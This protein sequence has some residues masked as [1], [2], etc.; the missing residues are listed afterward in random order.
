[1]LSVLVV[2]GAR[3]GAVVEALPSNWKVADSITDGV[4]EIFY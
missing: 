2:E 1:M 3:G 4:T